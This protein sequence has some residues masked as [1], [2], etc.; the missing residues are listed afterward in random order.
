MDQYLT[1]LIPPGLRKVLLKVECAQFIQN[2][3]RFFQR[4]SKTQHAISS[5]LHNP[6]LLSRQRDCHGVKQLLLKAN[7][8]CN[9]IVVVRNHKKHTSKRRIIKQSAKEM[10]PE[11]NYDT[12]EFK[13]SFLTTMESKKVGMKKS[14][15]DFLYVS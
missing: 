11:R 7:K 13:F 15:L 10:N 14:F 5:S 8:A 4:L 1:R 3:Y 6:S 9:L 12:P 2:P